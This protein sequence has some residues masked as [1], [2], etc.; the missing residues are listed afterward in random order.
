MML[1]TACYDTAWQAGAKLRALHGKIRLR[2]IKVQRVF[3]VLL[4]VKMY[5]WF[6]KKPSPPKEL[7]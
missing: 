7:H 6:S 5:P 1:K 2:F 4:L 3:T